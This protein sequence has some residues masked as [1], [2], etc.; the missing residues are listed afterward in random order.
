MRHYLQDTFRKVLLAEHVWSNCVLCSVMQCLSTLFEN[1]SHCC[2][3]PNLEF[4]NTMTPRPGHYPHARQCWRD[5][6]LASGDGPCYIL[7]WSVCGSQT[8]FWKPGWSFCMRKHTRVLDAF[9]FVLLMVVQNLKVLLTYFLNSAGSSSLYPRHIILKV[10]G[11]LNV[12]IKLL[13]IWSSE[14][15]EKKL[16][17][18]CFMSML[19]FG[20][21][22]AWLLK[23]LC[24][25]C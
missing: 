20:L 23:W 13:S 16:T 8:K 15:V 10:M 12:H 24:Y 22:D 11:T 7:G 6:I 18:G 1:S 17:V 21:W 9:S 19:D 14:L 2:V 5:E 3:Q 4:R 25:G